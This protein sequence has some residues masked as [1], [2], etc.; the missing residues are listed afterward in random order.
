VPVPGESTLAEAE[1]GW[2]AELGGGGSERVGEVTVTAGGLAGKAGLM[3]RVVG[4]MDLEGLVGLGLPWSGAC[5]LRCSPRGAA[6]EERARES[7]PP[8]MRSRSPRPA[9][10]SEPVS[11]LKGAVGV[12]LALVVT[13]TGLGGFGGGGSTWA[14][15][16]LVRAADGGELADERLV[17]S[18]DCCSGSSA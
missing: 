5:V 9:S 13:Q 8:A 11:M 6:S 4:E 14:D 1:A 2:E 7:P 18:A 15:L 17:G 10:T 3:L 16:P 12:S